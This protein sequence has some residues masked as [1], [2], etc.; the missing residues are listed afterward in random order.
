MKEKTKD[1]IKK[2]VVTTAMG[3]TTIAANAQMPEVPT[4]TGS[5]TNAQSL[6]DATN[7][8]GNFDGLLVCPTLTNEKINCL[9]VTHGI[10]LG[11]SS[12]AICLA[13]VLVLDFIV[14]IVFVAC[15]LFTPEAFVMNVTVEK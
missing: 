12:K 1:K 9:F 4:L 3:V 2:V 6:L 10:P 5:A 11:I 7:T 13:S 14:N 15:N 8:V